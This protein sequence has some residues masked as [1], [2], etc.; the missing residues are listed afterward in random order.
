MAKLYLKY[1]GEDGVRHGDWSSEDKES[2]KIHIKYN[3]LNTNK[4]LTGRT[5]G[6]LYVDGY[7]G[8]YKTRRRVK[9]E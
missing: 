2:K 4:E 1:I 6:E 7:A 5:F 3:K 9:D 8:S